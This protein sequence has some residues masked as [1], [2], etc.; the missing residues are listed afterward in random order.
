MR[1]QSPILDLPS[2]PTVGET[3]AL[4]AF[5]EHQREAN[6]VHEY[7]NHF[8]NGVFSAPVTRLEA[9]VSKTGTLYD[10]ERLDLAMQ[11]A[12][13]LFRFD[14]MQRYSLIVE[15]L[16]ECANLLADAAASRQD[17]LK[18]ARLAFALEALIRG[19]F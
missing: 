15:M 9:Q 8:L 4:L 6:T 11:H 14:R 2:E 5:L 10:L 19:I 13:R 3:I 16:K 1:L 17:K 7:T 18:S 12:D